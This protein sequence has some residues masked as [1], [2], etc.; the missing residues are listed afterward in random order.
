MDRIKWI[1]ARGKK[2]LYVDWSGLKK[3]ED[4]TEVLN[5]AVKVAVASPTKLLTISDFTD[6]AASSEFMDLINKAGKEVFDNKSEK[7]AVLGI[8]GVKSILLQGYLRVTGAKNMKVCSSRDDA[9]NYLT[10]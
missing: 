4:L 8:S 9:I 6:A 10:L 5:E 7:S 3:L 1:D 2:I